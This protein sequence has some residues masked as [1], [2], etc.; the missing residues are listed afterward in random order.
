MDGWSYQ[1]RAESFWKILI[2]KGPIWAYNKMDQ[3]YFLY[4]HQQD[5]YSNPLV[6]GEKYEYQEQKER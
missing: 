4:P 2:R 5:G 6:K 3:K 1:E